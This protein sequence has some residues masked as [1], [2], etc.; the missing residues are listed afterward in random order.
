METPTAANPLSTKHRSEHSSWLTQLMFTGT[1]CAG[2]IIL[3]TYRGTELK[4]HALTSHWV[5]DPGLKPNWAN[6]SAY[7]PRPFTILPLSSWWLPRTGGWHLLEPRC[8]SQDPLQVS[9]TQGRTGSETRTPNFPGKGHSAEWPGL[10][11]VTTPRS[12][13]K[14]WTQ[15]APR[16]MWLLNVCLNMPPS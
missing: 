2:T 7:S 4:W 5:A 12:T 14:T 9:E 11:A 13:L 10:W 6:T 1:Q 15:K 3:P 16:D 8:A